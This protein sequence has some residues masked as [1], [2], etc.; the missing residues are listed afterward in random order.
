MEGKYSSGQMKKKK[1]ILKRG[2]EYRIC[3]PKISLWH[4]DYLGLIIWRNCRHRR[5]S[6]SRE[7]TLL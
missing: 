5:S 3:H 7:V 1:I 4:Q 2:E 6:K